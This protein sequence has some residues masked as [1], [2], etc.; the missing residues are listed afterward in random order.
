MGM[1]GVFGSSQ[2]EAPSIGFSVPILAFTFGFWRDEKTMKTD[3]FRSTTSL[4][5]SSSTTT[6]TPLQVEKDQPFLF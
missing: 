2:S 3:R 1:G 5:W 4:E 6:P